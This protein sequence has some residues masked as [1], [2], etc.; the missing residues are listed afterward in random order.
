VNV[1][2]TADSLYNALIDILRVHKNYLSVKGGSLARAA[3]EYQVRGT[4]L[5][6]D[7]LHLKLDRYERAY[8]L[9]QDQ[10]VDWER[11]LD[12][13]RAIIDGLEGKDVETDDTDDVLN[14]VDKAAKLYQPKWRG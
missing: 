9:L 13:L 7:H 3:A 2:T 12:N 11:D 10:L 8:E 5:A 6:L 1:T 4:H 14:W